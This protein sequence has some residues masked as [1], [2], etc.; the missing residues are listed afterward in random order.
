MGICE[1][2]CQLFGSLT[3][4]QLLV[5]GWYMCPSAAKNKSTGRCP[6]F[7]DF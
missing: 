1:Q 6:I 5:I 4:E 7:I 3:S 2:V